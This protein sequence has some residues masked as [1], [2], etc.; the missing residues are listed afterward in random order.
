M[1]SHYDCPG[2]E[3]WG[4]GVVRVEFGLKE[5]GADLV[6][7]EQQVCVG[8]CDHALDFGG[9]CC[10]FEVSVEAFLGLVENY[11]GCGGI[12]LGGCQG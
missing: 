12:K 7:A 11:L 3:G 4:G 5:S 1:V 6:K 10:L 8:G 2:D 9:A